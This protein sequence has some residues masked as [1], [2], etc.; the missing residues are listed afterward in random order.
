VEP[1]VVPKFLAG[2]EA[3]GATPQRVEAYLTA[4]GLPGPAWC[5]AEAALLAE[6]LVDAI[7]FSSQAEVGGFAGGGGGHQREQA[8][9]AQEPEWW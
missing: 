3:A 2:L 6:G 4:P 7:A 8:H 9:Q 1:P 5:G